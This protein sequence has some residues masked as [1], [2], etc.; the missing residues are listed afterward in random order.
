MIVMMTA[1]MTGRVKNSLLEKEREAQL[2]EIAMLESKFSVMQHEQALITKLKNQ[3]VGSSH[4]QVNF[5]P[6]YDNYQSKACAHAQAH[7]RMGSVV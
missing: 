4:H 2:H 5:L 3:A 6:L 7:W 1:M